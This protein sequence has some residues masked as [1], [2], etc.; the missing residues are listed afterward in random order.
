MMSSDYFKIKGHHYLVM[1]CR[2]SGWSTIYKTK[3]NTAT[4]LISRLW[5]HMVTFG[6]MDEL[7][8]DGATVY[9]STDIQ[10]FLKRFSIRH[11]VSSAYNP[12]SN[13]L[14]AKNLQSPHP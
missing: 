13:Q 4:K 5:E 3:D 6:V 7:A 11:R 9:M 14:V 8:T 10:E 2:Y 1:A 12:H